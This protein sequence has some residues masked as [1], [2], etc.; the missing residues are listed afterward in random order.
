MNV[1]FGYPIF[2]FQKYNKDENDILW[3]EDVMYAKQISHNTV[4]IFL[5]IHLHLSTPVK[6]AYT[7]NTI[8]QPPL[9]MK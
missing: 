4:Q 8:L 6:T 5:Y 9:V 7:M 1:V 3:A 2:H